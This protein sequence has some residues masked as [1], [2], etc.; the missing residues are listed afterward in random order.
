MLDFV[1]GEIV[2]VDYD[3]YDP[4]GRVLGKVLLDG[5]DVNLEQIRAILGGGETLCRCRWDYRLTRSEQKKCIVAF[6]IRSEI[7]G[8]QCLPLVSEN[9]RV[10][11]HSAYITF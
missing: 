1:A 6:T 10:E 9:S 4:Y 2:V 7:F 8:T 5:E 3:K 11:N